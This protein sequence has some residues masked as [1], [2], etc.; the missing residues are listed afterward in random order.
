MLRT[1]VPT[2]MLISMMGSFRNATGRNP[3][4]SRNHVSVA[5]HGG[6]PDITLNTKAF[7]D[8]MQ[9][10]SEKGGGTLTVPKGVWFTGPIS[11]ARTS[12]CI[13]KKEH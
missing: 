8:A 11:S 2:L 12:T 1:I 6:K 5:D 7:E 13:L 9:A 4:L 3:N 10:L